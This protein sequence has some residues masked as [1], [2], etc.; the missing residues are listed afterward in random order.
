MFLCAPVN[1]L[2]FAHLQ[3]YV[4]YIYPGSFKVHLIAQIISPKFK[5]KYL[6][7][8]RTRVLEP[9]KAHPQHVVP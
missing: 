9:Y 2:M 3:T 5:D 4:M 6:I 7:L 8:I 1:I